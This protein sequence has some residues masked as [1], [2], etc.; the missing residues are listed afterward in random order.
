MFSGLKVLVML[1]MKPMKNSRQLATQFNYLR[2]C[3]KA[4]LYEDVIHFFVSILADPL[5]RSGKD[6]SEQVWARCCDSFNC[7]NADCVGLF[8]HGVGV[9]A[10]PQLVSDSE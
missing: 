2:E 7:T 8:S 4:F 10:L 3:K 1:T 6:R 9:D 5:S